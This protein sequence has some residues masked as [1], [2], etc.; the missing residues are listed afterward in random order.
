MKFLVLLLI[1]SSFQSFGQ[2]DEF[3][4]LLDSTYD[5]E[6]PLIPLDDAIKLL[7]DESVVFLD[8]REINEFEVSHIE[9]AI[10][11]GFDSF[12][13]SSINHI[14]KDAKIIV[15]CSIGARS[16]TIAQKLIEAGYSNV[17]NLYGGLFNWANHDFPMVDDSFKDTA[18]IHGFSKEWGKWVTKGLIV[19]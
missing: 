14:E 9:S 11:V 4:S 5:E 17:Q 8:T 7:Y 15:Y 6:T 13:L 18:I 2:T 16:Q 19:Y 3:V 1:F 12:D 10:N